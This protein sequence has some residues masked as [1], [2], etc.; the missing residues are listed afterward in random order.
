MKIRVLNA[1]DVPDSG[2]I[3]V[4]AKSCVFALSGGVSVVQPG[5]RHL[6]RFWD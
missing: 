1:I 5:M 6:S 2:T 4:W 3:M